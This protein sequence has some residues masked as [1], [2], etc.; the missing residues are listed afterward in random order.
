MVVQ[1]L[2]DVPDTLYVSVRSLADDHTQVLIYPCVCIPSFN[3]AQVLRYPCVCILS[4]NQTQVLKHF[5]FFFTLVTGPSRSLSLK[6]S[7][8]KVYEPQIRLEIPLCLHSFIHAA[9][10][11]SCS[12]SS[13][14]SL[15]N[16]LK[17]RHAS[18]SS[19]LL[20]SA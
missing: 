20:L 12:F 13:P 15:S 4:F 19:F 11:F 9:F 1:V 18:S 6:L 3:Q 17:P 5:F 14:S 7:D 2:R 16:T 8:T 10:F